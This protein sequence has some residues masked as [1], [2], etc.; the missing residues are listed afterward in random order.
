MHLGDHVGHIALPVAAGRTV[1]ES[2]GI[3][4]EVDTLELTADHTLYHIF[5]SLVLVGKLQIRP[6]LGTRVAQPHGMDIAGVYK[7][8]VLALVALAVMYCGV[9]GVGETIL[10]HPGQFAVGKHLFY[11]CD[12]GLYRLGVEQT[13]LP[14]GRLVLIYL[15]AVLTEVLSGS[16][17]GHAD[18]PLLHSNTAAV[19]KLNANLFMIMSLL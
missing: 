14:S 6:H 9:D 2:I 5:E 11:L 10:E 7:G 15:S 18:T 17:T 3:R 19:A 12:L 1:V 8:I 16:H 4:I 13:G